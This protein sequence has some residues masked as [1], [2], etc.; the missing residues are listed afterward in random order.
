M[1]C[2]YR[3]QTT[4]NLANVQN[5]EMLADA[6]RSLGARNVTVSGDVVHFTDE[7]G[8]LGTVR[9]GR[10]S[11]DNSSKLS[12]AVTVQR[13]YAETT[14]RTAAKKYGW[15]IKSTGQGQLQMTKQSFGR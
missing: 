1:P 15:Q 2:Y 3:Q 10:I 13:A 14:V 12:N 8:Y 6:L 7:N 4:V 11:V 5:K 9:D